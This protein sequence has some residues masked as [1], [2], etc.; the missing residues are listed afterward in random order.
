ME[1]KSEN[2]RNNRIEILILVRKKWGKKEWKVKRE[3]G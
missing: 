2:D 1:L 3:V